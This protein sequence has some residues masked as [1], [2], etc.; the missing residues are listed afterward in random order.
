MSVSKWDYSPE[1]CDGEP[2]PGDCDHC[3]ISMRKSSGRDFTYRRD[4]LINRLNRCQVDADGTVHMYENTLDAVID[5]FNF[6][7]TTGGQR[8]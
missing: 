1:I 7:T 5:F 8:K 3:S 2:C 4:D 6:F